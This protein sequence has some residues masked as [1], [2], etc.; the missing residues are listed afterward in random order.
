MSE[1]AVPVPV[2]VVV[3]PQESPD[4]TMENQY[5]VQKTKE[6]LVKVFRTAGVKLD[7]VASWAVKRKRRDI[8]KLLAKSSVDLDKTDSRGFTPLGL[9]VLQG[10]NQ[11]CHILAEAGASVDLPDGFGNTPLRYASLTHRRSIGQLLRRHVN[12]SYSKEDSPE[13]SP[14]SS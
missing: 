4:V 9:A 10:D 8:L 7:K 5:V 1:A 13:S 6:D 14:S 2:N 11:T 12:K 3:P